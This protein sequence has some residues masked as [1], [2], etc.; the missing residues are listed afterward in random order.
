[1]KE[2][3][4]IDCKYE[5]TAINPCTGNIHTHMDG[6]V[7]L[8][9]DQAFQ[10]MVAS[11]PSI[12][13]A[14]GADPGQIA[15]A[16][17]L[18]RRILAYGREV[19]TKV[20]DVSNTCE[21]Q[22]DLFISDDETS[23]PELRDP[24]PAEDL[25]YPA[26]RITEQ[27]VEGAIVNEAYWVFPDTT[28]TV[29]CLTLKNGF[30]VIGYSAAVSPENFNAE[31]GEQVAREEALN[32]V[33]QLEGYLLKEKLYQESLP[34]VLEEEPQTTWLERAQSEL[35]ALTDRAAKLQRFTQ[36]EEYRALEEP[37]RYDLNCQL[38]AMVR[39]HSALQSRISRHSADTL[40]Q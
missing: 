20:P 40:R 28:V 29:C 31:K 1:M 9:H 26:P 2:R 38:E 27:D 39:Y 23:P 35:A 14:L 25:A 32:E 17:G 6:V 13:E 24:K 36:S 22:R 3:L 7:F 15:G 34:S 21:V 16:K 30:N 5:F 10:I 12:C 37:D 8:A 19:L 11:Y 18:V 4:P 33:W